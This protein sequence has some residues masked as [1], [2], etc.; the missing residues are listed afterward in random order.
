MHVFQSKGQRNI[1]T[2]A[3]AS[4]WVCNTTFIVTFNDYSYKNER[5]Q[6]QIFI[7]TKTFANVPDF[8]RNILY[9]DSV[10]TAALPK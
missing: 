4:F 9:V 1:K 6:R 2:Y 7:L 8:R 5:I 10:S 3:M